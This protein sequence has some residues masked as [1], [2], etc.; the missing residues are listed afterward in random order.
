MEL[1]YNAQ[2][3]V[4]GQKATLTLSPQKAVELKTVHE[5][6]VHLIIISEDLSYFNHVHPVETMKGYM[7]ETKFPYSGKFY[8]FADYVPLNSDHVVNKLEVAVP[9]K[10]PAHQLYLEEKLTGS[11]GAYSINLIFDNRKFSNCPLIID[12]ILKKDGEEINPST[13]DNYLGVKAHVVLVSVDDKEY[14][15]VHPEV[16]NGRYKL[17]TSFPL[18]YKS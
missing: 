16:E 15:H 8:L 12:G 17:H 13:L 11:S 6:K 4:P 10:A 3:T 14:I 7:V 18:C 2:T 5:Q 9:G 1:K